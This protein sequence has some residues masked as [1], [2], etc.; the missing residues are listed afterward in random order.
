M[1]TL[2][3]EQISV[4]TDTSNRLVCLAGAGTGKT[5]TMLYKILEIIKSG[6]SPDSILAL[7]FTHAAA[8]EMKDRYLKL[9]KSKQSPRFCT[10]HAFCYYIISIDTDIRSAIGYSQVPDIASD[11]QIKDIISKAELMTGYKATM[12]KGDK[13]TKSEKIKYQYKIYQK[14]V[15]KLYASQ[16]L[17]TFDVLC[18]E[19]CRLFAENSDL[20][21]K[22]KN[23][24]KYIFVDEFQD[25]DS[26]QFDFISSFINSTIFVV[27]DICQAIYGFRGATS[28]I[29]KSLIDNPEWEVLR[30][31]QNYRSTQKI[32]DFANTNTSYLDKKYFIDLKSARQD[33]TGS[34]VVVRNFSE[35]CKFFE[36]VNSNSLKWLSEDLKSL[37]GSTAIL[38]RTN[39][40]VAS[41]QEYLK[42][43][44]IIFSAKADDKVQV[45]SHIASAVDSDEYLISWIATFLDRFEYLQFQRAAYLD[46]KFCTTLDDFYSRWHTDKIKDILSKIFILR[47]ILS[48]S[49]PLEEKSKSLCEILEIPFSGVPE[50]IEN[51]KDFINKLVENSIEQNSLMLKTG[52]YS[53]TIHSVKGLE[54]DNV[55]LIGVD[56]TCF[57][58][59]TEENNNLYYVGITRA[60]TNLFVYKYKNNM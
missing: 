39:N 51:N 25:T 53:G 56:D 42:E 11:A 24:Y 16:N 35:R 18:S 46:G 57:K 20:V 48:N 33:C 28:S 59:N 38:C 5:Y 44:N 37:T 52:I 3:Q 26:V 29:I 58:L 34:K 50:D 49:D 22:Y 60:K 31:E 15:K 45:L 13:K 7:T 47:S 10:F 4:V 19:V 17:I 12:F 9:S 55:I 41:I 14:T 6:A 40:E 54:F 30:L 43:Q 32:C 1:S 2:N 8:F 21:T 36:S 23:K 27:G